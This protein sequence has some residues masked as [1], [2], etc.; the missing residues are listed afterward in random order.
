MSEYLCRHFVRSD[1]TDCNGLRHCRQEVLTV[2]LEQ[3]LPGRTLVKGMDCIH[4]VAA[5]ELA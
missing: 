3:Y 5:A 1:H 4:K 2:I